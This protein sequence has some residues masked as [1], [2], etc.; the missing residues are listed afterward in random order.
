MPTEEWMQETLAVM[1][2]S[3]S[4]YVAYCWYDAFMRYLF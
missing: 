1:R 3:L 2:I 4:Y